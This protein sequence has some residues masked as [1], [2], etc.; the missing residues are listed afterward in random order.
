MTRLLR[1]PPR[2]RVFCESSGP[3]KESSAPLS[4][5]PTSV[6][7]PGNSG[8]PH[9]QVVKDAFVTLTAYT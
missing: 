4:P 1:L 9:A 3:A 6:R 8:C 2:L 7:P 5:T